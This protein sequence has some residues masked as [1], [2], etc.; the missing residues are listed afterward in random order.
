VREGGTPKSQGVSGVCVSD[1][2]GALARPRRVI[3]SCVMC[4]GTV[5][6]CFFYSLKEAH[7]YKML[8]CG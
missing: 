6:A 3:C 1:S 4:L 7:G 5:P 8:V 2:A